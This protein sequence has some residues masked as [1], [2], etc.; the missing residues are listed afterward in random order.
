MLLAGDVQLCYQGS[1][2]R[3]W[4]RG[5]P[6]EGKEGA[7]L[8]GKDSLFKRVKR[9]P[10]PCPRYLRKCRIATDTEHF[11]LMRSGD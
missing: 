9:Q 7:C 2:E 6:A 1:Q 8:L 3:H 4:L 11:H 10:D 5:E